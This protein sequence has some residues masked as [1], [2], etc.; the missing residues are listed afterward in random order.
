[1]TNVKVYQ[2]ST[3]TKMLKSPGLCVLFQSFY[4]MLSRNL[5]LFPILILG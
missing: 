1:M 4:L 3:M 2:G 5:D